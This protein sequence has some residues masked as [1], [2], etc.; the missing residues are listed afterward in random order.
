M[1]ILG[2][3]LASLFKAPKVTEE[4]PVIKDKVE[5]PAEYTETDTDSCVITDLWDDNIGPQE[6]LDCEPIHRIMY[7]KSFPPACTLN[8]DEAEAPWMGGSEN[9]HGHIRGGGSEEIHK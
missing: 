4:A 2:F 8:R 3:D 5:M 1:K 7:E 9:Y 6:P